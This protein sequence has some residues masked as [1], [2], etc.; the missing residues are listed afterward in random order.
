MAPLP[1]DAPTAAEIAPETA[2]AT[3]AAAAAPAAAAPAAAAPAATAAASAQEATL[4]S[5]LKRRDDAHELRHQV[6]SDRGTIAADPEWEALY[7][8]LKSM[9]LE[10]A[11]R[12]RKPGGCAHY[13]S[14]RR[15]YCGSRAGDGLRGRARPLVPVSYRHIRE[16]C[17][18][19]S[20]PATCRGQFAA[21]VCGVHCSTMSKQS[22]NER[23]GRGGGCGGCVR[24]GTPVHH[25][26]KV[27][28]RVARP[29]SPPHTPGTPAS[30]CGYKYTGTPRANSEGTSGAGPGRWVLQ[31]TRAAARAGPAVSG[32]PRHRMLFNSTNEGSKCGERCGERWARQ[33]LPSTS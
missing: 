32:E 10:E 18:G 8:Q 17:Q 15:R 16:I 20:G 25:E 21:S 6:K 31:P 22:G 3:A 14:R 29:F 33:T 11:G 7:Q 13:I 23:P 4:R 30:V 26:W 1:A 2:A 28:T 19:T 12:H 9:E 24:V 5:E 27:R